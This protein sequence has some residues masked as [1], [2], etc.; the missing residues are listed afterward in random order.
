VIYI[1]KQV[2]ATRNENAYRTAKLYVLSEV[3]AKREAGRF[4]QQP[5][6]LRL[7]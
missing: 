3:Q 1:R 4:P 5:H 6:R 2:S 7:S